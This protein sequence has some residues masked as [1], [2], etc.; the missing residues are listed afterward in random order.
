[1]A[2]T[3][4]KTRSAPRDHALVRRIKASE[5][6]LLRRLRL[7][8]LSDAPEAFGERLSHA[9]GQSVGAWAA[10]AR[11][12]S[13]G[14]RRAWFV[15]ERRAPRDATAHAVGLVQARRRPP[16]SCLLF[17]MWV[18]PAA[19]GTGVGRALL[20]AVETWASRWGAREIV[21]WVFDSNRPAIRLY[22]TGGFEHLTSGS[23]AEAGI[24][25]QALAMRRR[26]GP[27][28]TP[29]HATGAVD[30]RPRAK[31]ARRGTEPRSRS[32]KRR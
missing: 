2:S 26:I 1:V 7:A 9:E 16:D 6:P 3:K 13:R 4:R 30:S 14:D 18:D 24:Q 20:D 10:S 22:E 25:W 27:A 21:L 32:A 17:S 23:D 15:A 12:A 28:R 31:A 29:V 11:A 8:S 19:R 5:G